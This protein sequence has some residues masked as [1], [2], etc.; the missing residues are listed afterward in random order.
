MVCE[1]C[2]GNVNVSTSTYSKSKPRSFLWNLFMVCITGGFWLIW[3]LVRRKKE[4]IVRETWATC[5]ECGNR[6]KIG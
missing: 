2:G 3:M 5:T 6:W 4:K 1:K